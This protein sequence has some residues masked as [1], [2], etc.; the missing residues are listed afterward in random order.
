MA[1]FNRRHAV[2]DADDDDLFSTCGPNDQTPRRMAIG[3]RGGNYAS[4]PLSEIG[5]IAFQLARDTA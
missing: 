5:A 4:T 2:D 1:L 3:L